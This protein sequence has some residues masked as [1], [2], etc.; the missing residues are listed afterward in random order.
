M[1]NAKSISWALVAIML[2]SLAYWLAYQHGAAT[3]R[4]R[5]AKANVGSLRQ[6]GVR[7]RAGNND[8]SRFTATGSV[9]APKPRTQE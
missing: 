9:S 8:L 6:V 1:K 7:F 5:L 2:V 3:T 4:A